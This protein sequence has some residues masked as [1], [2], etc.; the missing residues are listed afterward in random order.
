MLSSWYK[1]FFLHQ[2]KQAGEDEAKYKSAANPGSCMVWLANLSLFH[3]VNFERIQIPK[4]V[5]LKIGPSLPWQFCF[6]FLVLVL[7]L[8][9]VGVLVATLSTPLHLAASAS[10]SKSSPMQRCWKGSS[11]SLLGWNFWFLLE[12]TQDWASCQPYLHLCTFLRLCL[13]QMQSNAKVFIKQQCTMWKLTKKV[14]ESGQ[15]WELIS[16][17]FF[18]QKIRIILLNAVLTPQESL[19]KPVAHF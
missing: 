8:V 9:L 10:F 17:V 14:T 4:L 16:A 13:F 11:F 15:L 2:K 19:K 5:L 12:T 1:Q 7:V 3:N 18:L 6:G